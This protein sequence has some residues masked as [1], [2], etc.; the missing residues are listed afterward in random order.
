MNGPDAVGPTKA[1]VLRSFGR[2]RELADGFGNPS[3]RRDDLGRQLA[4]GVVVSA[5]HVDS[6]IPTRN[7]REGADPMPLP[8]VV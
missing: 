1:Q 4:G 7:P 6:M 3:N 8:G 2:G 5:L